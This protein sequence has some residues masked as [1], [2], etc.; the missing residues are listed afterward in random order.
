MQ[1]LAALLASFLAVAV[2]NV[3]ILFLSLSLLHSLTIP[4]APGRARALRMPPF[5]DRL[6][7]DTLT[8]VYHSVYT[9]TSS[10]TS[11][12]TADSSSK[13]LAATTGNAL[14]M[15]STPPSRMP[16]A[17]PIL[18]FG[19]VFLGRGQIVVVGVGCSDLSTLFYPKFKL[20]EARCPSRLTADKHYVASTL[21]R[22]PNRRF[23]T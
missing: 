9:A 17:P 1:L 18:P 13:P 23:G 6:P 7:R 11:S 10:R 14:G 20:S 5:I 15:G 22:Y 8:R 4:A 16:P 3:G 2:A 21:R 19:M 12:V